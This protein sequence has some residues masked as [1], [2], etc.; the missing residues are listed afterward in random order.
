MPN[1]TI[2]FSNSSHKIG[3]YN[4]FGPTFKN[5][6]FFHETLQQGKFEGADF[7]YDN[8]F[9]KLLRKT[10]KVFFGSKFKNSNFCTKLCN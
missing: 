1:M 4:M 5:F 10:L 3:T 2:I 6:H 7:K 8:G 9:S